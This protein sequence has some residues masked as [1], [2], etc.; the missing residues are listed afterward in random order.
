[1]NR[2]ARHIEGFQYPIGVR[3][4]IECRRRIRAGS[5]QRERGCYKGLLQFHCFLNAL[6][7]ATCVIG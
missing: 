1:M 3:I 6:S 4:E 5:S 2:H 7:T